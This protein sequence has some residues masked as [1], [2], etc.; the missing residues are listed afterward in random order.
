MDMQN[1]SNLVIPEGEVRTIHDKDNRLIWGRVNYDTKYAGDTYQQTY[2]GTNLFDYTDTIE[3]ASGV[4]VG[5]DGWVTITY[6]NSGGGT[7]K[8]LNYYTNKLPLST[9]TNYNILL[10]IKNSTGNFSLYPVSTASNSQFSANWYIRSGSISDGGIY[11]AVKMTNPDFNNDIISLRTT[12]SLSPGNSGSVTFRISLLADTSITPGTFVYQPY[13]GGVPAPNPDYPQEIQTVTGEQTV[14]VHGKNLFS[15]YTKGTKLTPNNGAAISEPT[16]AS[17]DYIPLS[18]TGTKKAIIS[19]LP[20]NLYNFIAAYNADKV[21]LGRTGAGN[22]PERLLSVSAFSGGTPQGT[23]DIAFL[24]VTV[25]ENP[26]AQGVID[27]IDNAKIQL[28]EG[29][30]ATGYQPYQ[31]Q[32][33]EINLIGKNLFDKDNLSDGW[34]DT[35][36][37]INPDSSW[38]HTDYIPITPSTPYTTS[39]FVNGGGTN[40][41]RCYYDA[42]KVFISGVKHNNAAQFV[43]TSPSNARYMRE[44]CKTTDIDTLQIE[45][46]SSA[47]SYAPYYNH[48]LCKLGTYQDYIY[49]SGNNWYVHK[50]VQHLSLG[51]SDMDNN[52][53]YPGWRNMTVLVDTLGSDLN[54]ALNRITQYLAN[55]LT[56]DSSSADTGILSTNTRGTGSL[57]FQNG[58]WSQTYWKTNY[59]NL[60][61][62]L[63]Y[64]ILILQADNQITDDTLIGQLNAVH[65][66]LT[67]YGYSSNVTGNLPIIIDRTNL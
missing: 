11:S 41:A 48:E 15:G 24:R 53:R 32:S 30:V 12:L 64:G 60:S 63:Y 2:S 5:D 56:S 1:V 66:W 3:V 67:R 27:D 49:K 39:G 28:E 8:Y 43:N 26:N 23:G 65:E 50:E 52:E 59:P 40:P 35:T 25:Y 14:E 58:N 18:I 57:F 46:G 62:E 61:L 20:N 17:S 55:I 21:F 47:S 45:T 6:D 33:Y 44:C 22:I 29:S 31:S 19:G 4:T 16:A 13:T 10:E 36:G 7:T 51:I 54:N 42:N 34:F 37:N 9:S 38:K